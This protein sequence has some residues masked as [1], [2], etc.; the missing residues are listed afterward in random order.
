MADARGGAAGNGHDP[1]PPPYVGK[2]KHGRPKTSPKNA[3]RKLIAAMQDNPGLSV[4]ALANAAG[5]SRS[6]TGERIETDGA[7][8]RGREERDWAMEAEGRGAGPSAAVAELTAAA[9]PETKPEPV[10]QLSAREPWVRN[11]NDYTRQVTS[12]LQGARYG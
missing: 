11:V 1:H 5:S 6:A 3:E 2:R 9:E 8:R 10:A 12:E 4:I 7:A